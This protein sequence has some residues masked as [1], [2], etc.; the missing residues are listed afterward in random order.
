M[1]LSG[2][3]QTITGQMKYYYEK[4]M[5][6][7]EKRHRFQEYNANM[8][9]P[10]FDAQPIVMMLGQHSA[11]KTSFLR[12][13]LG[14][15]YDTLRVGACSTTKKFRI[16]T[17]NHR[18][19]EDTTPGQNL[20]HEFPQLKTL[21]PTC[22]DQLECVRLHNESLKDLVFIDTPGFTFD[23]YTAGSPLRK[24]LEWF[25]PRA[26]RI[27]IFFDVVKL[28]VPSA[29]GEILGGAC[30]S[31]Q[32]GDLLQKMH[33]VVNKAEEE[34]ANALFTTINEF[35][36]KL[37]QVIGKQDPS[38]ALHVGSFWCGTKE[39]PRKLDHHL[40]ESFRDSENQLIDSLSSLPKDKEQDLLRELIKR[41][42][43]IKAHAYFLDALR[44]RTSGWFR[45]SDSNTVLGQLP[46]VL[47]A[48]VKD[49]N[50][51]LH[52]SYFPNLIEMKE[53][54]EESEVPFS[55][56]EC[57]DKIAMARLQKLLDEDFPALQTSIN[58]RTQVLSAN[59]APNRLSEV[60]GGAQNQVGTGRSRSPRHRE[61]REQS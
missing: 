17:F 57:V 13:M 37:G 9:D 33:V 22:L 2:S 11:G 7:M 48:L 42:Q 40:S 23:N 34:S 47:Q 24:M 61:A 20:A 58:S 5:L 21:D 18:K 25:L 19:S 41:A 53:L 56:F 12:Y 45:G 59:L 38:P 8:S 29:L 28:D 51:K 52:E 35:Y 31:H 3:T 4:G 26:G 27:L 14:Q 43:R 10:H 16:V 55:K 46:E 44:D 60:K 36:F 54:L 49:D 50:K 30:N 6:P 1:G 32:P 15:S 39:K